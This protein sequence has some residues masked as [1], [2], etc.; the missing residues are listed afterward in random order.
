MTEQIRFATVADAKALLAIY[1]PYVTDTTITY[2]YEIPTV[3]D[4]SN[5]IASISN[6]YPYLV[7]VVD[8]EIAGYAYAS[9]FRPRKAFDWDVETSVYVKEEF[10]HKKVAH[11]L[12]TALFSL[13]EEQ[14]FYQIYAYIN[15]PNPK[16]TKFHEKFGFK[17]TAFYEN[18]GYKLGMWCNLSC[19]V[20]SLRQITSD[21]VPDAISS[22]HELDPAFIKKTLCL[23]GSET[24]G[25][26]L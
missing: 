19:M 16:S 4:F 5:R 21:T 17:E 8:G 13:L 6:A 12:Y 3:E 2:E 20:K 7:Y 26:R 14:G 25:T 11:K 18:T 10:H 15:A 9:R 1:A 24:D 22:V 23:T